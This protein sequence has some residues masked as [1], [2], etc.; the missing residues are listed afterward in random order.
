MTCKLSNSA[1]IEAFGTDCFVALGKLRHCLLTTDNQKLTPPANTDE[2]WFGD[3]SEGQFMWVFDEVWQL[4][5]PVYSILSFSTKQE[6][7]ARRIHHRETKR[8]LRPA[9]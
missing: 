8:S 6:R 4:R 2:Y 9:D 7:S 5:N 3:Y 1:P